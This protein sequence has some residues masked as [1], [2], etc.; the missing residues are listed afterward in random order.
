VEAGDSP[1]DEGGIGDRWRL[2]GL[3]KNA[4][5]GVVEVYD[6]GRIAAHGSLNRIL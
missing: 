6:T 3:R 1:E 2:E 5:D 4:E